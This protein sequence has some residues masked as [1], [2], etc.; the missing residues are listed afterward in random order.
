MYVCIYSININIY[1]GDST[2]FDLL[3]VWFLCY[4]FLNFSL[5]LDLMLSCCF[6]Y[7]MWLYLS[8]S[9][10]EWV[11][12]FY[13]PYNRECVLFI[14]YR[15]SLWVSYILL[16]IVSC[17]NFDFFLLSFHIQTS[18]SIL[19]G[20]FI[21]NYQPYTTYGTPHT[22][23]KE[24]LCTEPSQIKCCCVIVIVADMTAGVLFVIL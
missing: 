21:D 18:Q 11:S 22:H 4:F 20:I 16:P 17:C 5:T 14:F 8:L 3:I 24:R 23:S 10:C 12:M 9:L 1:T 15:V 7:I 13:L 19:I 6:Y 2:I